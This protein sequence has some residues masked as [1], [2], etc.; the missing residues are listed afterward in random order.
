MVF[1]PCREG[2]SHA[3]GESADPDNIALGVQ[4]MLRVVLELAARR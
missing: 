2:L 3:P 1:V 4:L